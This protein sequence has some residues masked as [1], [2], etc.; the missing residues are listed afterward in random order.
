M[1]KSESR[2]PLRR[3]APGILGA[4]L[5]LAAMLVP[6]AT[7]A[8]RD[9][10]TEQ[11]A[12]DVSAQTFAEYCRGD[13]PSNRRSKFSSALDTAE[14]ALTSSDRKAAREAFSEARSAAYRGGADSDLSV[15]CLGESTARR[16]FK[17][18]LELNRLQ[19]RV[20]SH[21][22]EDET[23]ALYVTAVEQGASATISLVEG[24][25]PRD[26]VAAI[27]TLDRIA[28]P[29]DRERRFGAFMLSEEEARAETCHRA[30]TSL[31]EQAA[32]EHRRALKP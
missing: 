11:F 27:Q 20:D 13:L 28:D 29:F 14:R 19:S 5:F 17:G 6:L 21:G 24:K 7:A 3:G 30:L 25:S 10:S 9:P 31:R 32:Q 22:R 15:K 2:S 4:S 1:R 12:G 26:F 16:W 8:D 23:A 18:Q